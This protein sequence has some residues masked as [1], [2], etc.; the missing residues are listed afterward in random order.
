MNNAMKTWLLIIA[1]ILVALNA[2]FFIYSTDLLSTLDSQLEDEQSPEALAKV[3][4][5]A[6]TS[7]PA[8]PEKGGALEKR[9]GGSSN[10]RELEL[11]AQKAGKSKNEA[12]SEED[13][14]KSKS[15]SKEV[16]RADEKEGEGAEE[17]EV[18]VIKDKYKPKLIG[19]CKTL[20]TKYEKKGDF[21]GNHRAFTY[22]FDGDS[23]YCAIVEQQ[24]SKQIAEKEALKACEKSKTDAATYA[25]CFVMASF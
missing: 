16:A 11:F 20:F 17:A 25:P 1:F 21:T 23:G 9:E 2:G 5:T 18:G 3:T 15:K 22:S 10:A 8:D 7:D 12:K 13:E 24:K 14:S 19:Q 6:K 4:Q